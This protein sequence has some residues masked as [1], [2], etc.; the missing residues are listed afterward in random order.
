MNS[1]E[2]DPEYYTPAS[3]FTGEDLNEKGFF[4]DAKTKSIL[5]DVCSGLKFLHENGIVHGEITPHNIMIDAYGEDN[6]IPPKKPEG[7]KKDETWEKL[8]KMC[9]N[10]C[11]R[12]NWR[13]DGRNRERTTFLHTF[14][15][16][17]VDFYISNIYLTSVLLKSRIFFIS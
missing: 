1:Q 4:A 3:V 9:E 13:G 6:Y 12:P 7:P 15:V 5:K 14:I 2:S 11:F 8:T 16:S 17:N 10:D